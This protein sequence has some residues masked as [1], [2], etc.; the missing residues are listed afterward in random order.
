MDFAEEKSREQLRHIALSVGATA[1]SFMRVWETNRVAGI[2]TIN[3]GHRYAVV[4]DTRLG[5]V[6]E[7]DL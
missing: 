1:A 5:I 2:M 4:Y 3:G 7:P 6:D